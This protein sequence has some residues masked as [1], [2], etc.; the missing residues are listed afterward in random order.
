MQLDEAVEDAVEVLEELGKWLSKAHNSPKIASAKENGM[1][2]SFIIIFNWQQKVDDVLNN[3]F[4]WFARSKHKFEKE[5]I[6]SKKIIDIQNR[7][8]IIT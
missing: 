5:E 6:L 2:V 4:A 8:R 7:F 3:Q 1:F